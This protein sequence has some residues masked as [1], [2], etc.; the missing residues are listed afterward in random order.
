MS[1]WKVIHKLTVT[2]I[3]K[4]IGTDF[5]VVTCYLK[6]N[7]WI[8]SLLF[9]LNG[10]ILLPIYV[11]GDPIQ[12]YEENTGLFSKITIM[13]IM[14][15]TYKVWI[16]FAFILLTS[17]ISIYRL[18]LFWIETNEY[19]YTYNSQNY[20]SNGDIKLHSII[21]KGVPRYLDVD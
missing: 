21:I 8:F 9:I 13:N 7:I 16:S 11:T 2:D 15:T 14:G 12:T 4:F 6:M 18:Y 1:W 5:A 19:R 20:L 3:N 10:I 17:G